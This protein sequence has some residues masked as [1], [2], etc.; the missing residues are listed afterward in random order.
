MRVFNP[1]QAS[2]GIVSFVQDGVHPHD[3]AEFLASHNIA[4]R[5]G[6]HCAPM[7]MDN[8]GVTATVRASAYVYTSENDIAL[9]E[10]KLDECRSFF[11]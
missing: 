5:A 7:A 3:T 9:L 11:V 4:V 8:A 1:D 2:G 6:R 10:E